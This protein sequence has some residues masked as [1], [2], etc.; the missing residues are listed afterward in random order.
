[1]LRANS[2]R[3][4][5][6]ATATILDRIAQQPQGLWMGGWNSDIYRAVEHFVARAT[7]EGAVPV[8]IAYNIPY[9]DYGAV[10]SEGGLATKDA[11]RRWIRDAYAGIGDHA[12]VV[13]LEPDALP[14]VSKLPPNLAAERME[15]LND[16]VRVMRQNPKIAVYIDSGHA[17]WLKPEEIAERLIKAGVEHASGFS[18]NTSNYRTT[19]ECLQ[20]GNAVSKLIGGK[21]FVIDTS[22]NGAG[23]F[24]SKVEEETWCNPPNRKLGK[25]PTTETGDPV[26][27]GFLWLKRP[28]ESDGE[29]NGGPK[30]GVFWMEQAMG[31]AQ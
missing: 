17:A 16:A 23:P 14:G 2:L 21:H 5:D 8:M 28:G 13:V 1:M 27:D 6:P 26:C 22:R 29:C 20:Y 7:A 12:A 15:L 25:P 9:R 10:H 24:E 18:I 11:Y 30:A 4:T 19:E 31:Y 3:A